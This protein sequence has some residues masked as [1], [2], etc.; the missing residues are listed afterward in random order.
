MTQETA[1]LV[2]RSQ[3]VNKKETRLPP[4]NLYYGS[5]HFCATQ[6]L[7]YQRLQS[8]QIRLL[9]SPSGLSALLKHFPGLSCW[10]LAPFF[11]LQSLHQTSRH[12]EKGS[13]YLQQAYRDSEKAFRRSEQASCHFN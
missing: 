2:A 10:S 12:L 6:Q 4:K 3:T 11:T 7:L 8:F 1:F 9:K 13:K 5:L